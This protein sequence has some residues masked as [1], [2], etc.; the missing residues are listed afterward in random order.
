[1]LEV[2]FGHPMPVL[3]PLNPSRYKLTFST[4][5]KRNNY[6]LGTRGEQKASEGEI[7]VKVG[8]AG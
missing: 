5:A 8:E 6:I 7:A 1:M 4:V 2:Y 3:A